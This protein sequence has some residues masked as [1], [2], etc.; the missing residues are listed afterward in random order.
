MKNDIDSGRPFIP[1]K[2]RDLGSIF[3]EWLTKSSMEV[4]HEAQLS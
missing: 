4:M 1:R 3:E 2:G